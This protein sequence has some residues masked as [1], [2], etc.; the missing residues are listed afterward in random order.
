[1]RIALR[2]KGLTDTEERFVNP[3][4]DDAGLI[5][6]NSAARVPVLVTDNNE[7]LSE[8][9]LILLWLEKQFPSPTL[10]AGSV[11][12]VLQVSGIAFG[13][14]EASVHSLVGRVICGSTFDEAPVGLRRRRTILNGLEQLEANPPKYIDGVPDLSVIIAVVTLDYVFF[15]FGEQSWLKTF[16]RLNALKEQLSHRASFT[17]TFPFG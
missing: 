3:W 16:P 11:G 10:L 7:N 6:A 14:I 13:V 12:N 1:V 5:A 2:E 15:R 8:S 17:D 4:A 9:L